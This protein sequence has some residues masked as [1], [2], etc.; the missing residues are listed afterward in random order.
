MDLEEFT[1]GIIGVNLV[2]LSEHSRS[3][4][5]K[6]VVSRRKAAL[7]SLTARLL[8]L[9]DKQVGK[10]ASIVRYTTGRYIEEYSQS[11]TDWLYRHS[12]GFN[13]KQNSTTSVELLEQK[14]IHFSNSSNFFASLT[15]LTNCHNNDSNSNSIETNNN[16]RMKNCSVKNS[17]S[18]Y[19]QQALASRV[20]LD[21]QIDNE[22]HEKQQM[23]NKLRWA[24]AYIVIYAINDISTFNKAIKYLNLIANNINSPLDNHRISRSTTTNST[25]S[26]NNS[27][28]SSSCSNIS[29]NSINNN[30][31]IQASNSNGLF[32][33][34][35]PSSSHQATGKLS[36]NHLNSSCSNN[37]LGNNNAAKR[38]ILLIGNKRDLEKGGA[39]QVSSIDGRM[40]AMRHQAMFAE[41]S[42]AESNKL[43]ESTLDCFID[44]IDSNGMH[45][46]HLSPKRQQQLLLDI[47]T[48]PK[49]VQ[50]CPTVELLFSQ[51]NLPASSPVWATLV[52]SQAIGASIAQSNR[53][54]STRQETDVRLIKPIGLVSKSVETKVAMKPLLATCN[55][56]SK[57]P[58]STSLELSG[59]ALIKSPITANKIISTPNQKLVNSNRYE[60]LKS[61]FRRA[62]MA[63]VSGKT[64]ARS[65]TRTSS[66]QSEKEPDEKKGGEV[67]NSF[68][69]VSEPLVE[70]N[71]RKVSTNSAPSSWIRSHIRLSRQESQK[72]VVASSSDPKL[73]SS[74]ELLVAERFKKPLFKYKSRTQTAVFERIVDEDSYNDVENAN[75]EPEQTSVEDRRKLSDVKLTQ[76]GRANSSGSGSY[77]STRCSSGRSSS[78]LSNADTSYGSLFFLCNS[79]RVP[80]ISGSASV[81][82]SN[83]SGTN[84]QQVKRLDRCNSR[85][86]LSRTSTSGGSGEETSGDEMLTDSNMTINSRVFHKA[87]SR[88]VDSCRQ[89]LP[90]MVTNAKSNNVKRRHQLVRSV[91][92]TLTNLTRSSNVAAKKSFCSAL[93]KHSIIDATA[94]VKILST[95]AIKL[96]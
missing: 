96:Q 46:D 37:N 85:S 90:P 71:N 9:G 80:S 82:S 3:S 45:V 53:I 40:L 28:S 68:D 81:C 30:F 93:F 36:P 10:S 76:E 14:D 60:N 66:K 62:S 24:N 89:T 79:E 5:N 39:R 13:A 92:G 22:M 74:G 87:S 1:N 51:A 88:G 55:T 52:K 15:S 41:V 70:R 72:P 11:T 32:N 23:L 57:R 49:L 50:W 4:F 16:N 47:E 8:V 43:I 65:L 33:R 77:N 83:Y 25:S 54:V 59:S 64:L 19:Q 21:Q 17:S 31:T 56:L 6:M 18:F 84:N 34:L 91:Q 75:K 26:F 44:Q 27:A 29:S 38:P 86:T 94:P 73:S 78:S 95:S 63:I 20:A 61:S 67:R 2:G 7:R 58:A 69:S 12:L 35:S 48:Q 42:I